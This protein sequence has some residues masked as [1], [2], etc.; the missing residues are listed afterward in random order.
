M[1]FHLLTV[2]N[3][4]C[5][6]WVQPKNADLE[7]IRT[8]MSIPMVSLQESLESVDVVYHAIEAR[9]NEDPMAWEHA[10]LLRQSIGMLV[11]YLPCLLQN[12]VKNA[13]NRRRYLKKNI[14]IDLETK[15]YPPARDI[16]SDAVPPMIVV[17]CGTIF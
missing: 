3:N 9:A 15:G 12:I 4:V 16:S 17:A 5:P 13:Q 10:M 1:L 7:F 11:G 8:S 2:A 6:E 14:Y